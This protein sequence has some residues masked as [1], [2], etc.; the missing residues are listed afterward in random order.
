MTVAPSVR[1]GRAPAGGGGRRAGYELLAV[2]AAVAFAG[3]LW[4]NCSEKPRAGEAAGQRAAES[5]AAERSDRRTIQISPTVITATPGWRGARGHDEKPGEAGKASSGKPPDP[6]L[7]LIAGDEHSE[8]LQAIYDNINARNRFKTDVDSFAEYYNDIRDVLERIPFSAYTR[9]VE[10]FSAEEFSPA[11]LGHVR[12]MAYSEKK[13][14]IRFVDAE[15]NSF[16]FWFNAETQKAS[17]I[18]REAKGKRIRIIGRSGNEFTVTHAGGKNYALALIENGEKALEATVASHVDARRVHERFV[19]LSSVSKAE[20]DLLCL[21]LKYGVRPARVFGFLNSE[22]NAW[23]SYEARAE[24]EAV[25]ACN[26]AAKRTGLPA[27]YIAAVAFQEGFAE[28]FSEKAAGAE[29][30]ISSFGDIGAEAFHSELGSIRA[31][32]PPGFSEGTAFR[33]AGGIVNEAGDS[34]ESVYFRDIPA[35]V[36]AVA[37]ILKGREARF[38]RFAKKSYG[39]GR[40]DLTDGQVLGGTYI[41]YNA[42]YANRRIAE[43]IRTGGFDLLARPYLDLA[44]DHAR[45]T[46]FIASLNCARVL[47]TAE[48]LRV[49]WPDLTRH[50]TG[51]T[52]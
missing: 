18:V 8:Q 30:G 41:T 37:A 13:D 32:L 46:I 6:L 33:L 48:F 10:M 27:W 19:F 23:D 42:A 39:K 51:F 16:E 5:A 47:A 52:Q 38:L 34:F 15:K 29:Y 45:P 28:N 12:G 4:G 44:P 31:F 1:S 43:R 26:E 35:T 50:A 21:T 9:F 14:C 49:L 11:M 2:S 40:G 17:L 25:K 24:A 7:A 22:V 3:F 20:F 36:H